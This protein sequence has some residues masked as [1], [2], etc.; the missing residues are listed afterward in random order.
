MLP[1][2]GVFALS[3][4][5]LDLSSCARL[6]PALLQAALRGAPSL[7]SLNLTGC[8]ECLTDACVPGLVTALSAAAA[9]REAPLQV[10]RLSRAIGTVATSSSAASVTRVSVAAL[11][12]LPHLTTL[13]LNNHLTLRDEDL[14][15]L[16]SAPTPV[17]ANDDGG[18]GANVEQGRYGAEAT[19]ALARYRRYLLT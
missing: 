12:A 10:F 18:S 5:D 15:P 17:R 4:T 1:G 9:P 6:S 8:H 11:S 7:T 3:L 19:A 2:N 16:I 14:L 13:A